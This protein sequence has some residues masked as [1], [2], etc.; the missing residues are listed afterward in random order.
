MSG[1]GGERQ[2]RTRDHP[3]A[4]GRTPQGGDVVWTFTFPLEDGTVLA[5]ECGKVGRDALIRMAHEEVTD[6]TLDAALSRH[7]AA[8]RADAGPGPVSS[9]STSG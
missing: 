5:V 1:A 3:L 4:N 2:F 7:R 6:D 9:P 8:A